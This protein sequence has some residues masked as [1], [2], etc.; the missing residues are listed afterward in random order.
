MVHS[1][2]SPGASSSKVHLCFEC[3]FTANSTAR[4]HNSGWRTTY[5]FSS[6]QNLYPLN[7]RVQDARWDAWECSNWR[8]FLS[9]F[10]HWLHSNRDTGGSGSPSGWLWARGCLQLPPGIALLRSHHSVGWQPCGLVAH[11]SFAKSCLLDRSLLTPLL[12]TVPLVLGPWCPQREAES[13]S[14]PPWTAKADVRSNWARQ[15]GAEAIAGQAVQSHLTASTFPLFL[16]VL[17]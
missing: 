1:S 11:P 9:S 17:I 16:S 10:Q 7:L 3:K 13:R 4:R 15:Q 5:V 12:F 6:G 2:A 14:R 8:H